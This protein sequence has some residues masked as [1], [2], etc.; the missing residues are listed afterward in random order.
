MEAARI[1]IVGG[2]FAGAT[3]AEHLNRR[4]A[5]D[6]EVV[7]I[8]SDNHMVFTPMLAEVAGRSL[9]GFDVVMPGR[10]MAPRA[11]WLTAT[12]TSVDL[13]TNEVEYTRPDG[14]RSTLSY[15]HLV[16]ACG[17]D[18][19]LDVV[20][21]MAAHA[22]TLRTV[23]DGMVL[24]NEV[25][26]RFEQAATEPDDAE[27]QRLL[28]VVVVGGRFTGVEAAGHLFDMMRSV[29]PYYPQLGRNRPQMVLLQR[30]ARI[31]PEFQHDSLSEFALRK[32]R[33]N[34]RATRPP[35][36]HRGERLRAS[37]ARTRNWLGLCPRCGTCSS[38][39]GMRGLC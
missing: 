18:V 5:R 14:K 33:Q 34:A 12:V 8:S 13:K 2:G 29:K 4:V 20:P 6:V 7:V 22:Y 25:I 9:S 39:S 31:V 10:Q 38:R 24:G 11:T 27:R 17:S 36:S 15:A 16:L 3:L 23:G 26:A 1:I 28:T 30:G 37:G 32:L 19:N 21:G 35:Y